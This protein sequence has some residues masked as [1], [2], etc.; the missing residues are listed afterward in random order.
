MPGNAHDHFDRYYA[1]KLWTMI[2]EYYREL[3]GEADTPGVL[4][5]FI[6]VLAQ[7]AATLR[8]SN[9]RLWDDQFIDL[10]SDWAVPYIGELVATRMLSPLLRRGRRIDVAKTVY[11]RRR[12]GTPRV[13]EELI[14]DITGWEGK[15]VEEF[16]LLGRARH[17]LDPEPSEYA[18]ALTGTMPG[19][20]ADLRNAHGAALAYSP[21][22][23]FHHTPDFR[24][25]DPNG[26]GRYG[27]YGIAKLGFHLYRLASTMVEDVTPLA[28]SPAGL[29]AGALAYTFDPSGR[30]IQ[31]FI[32]R[33]RTDDTSRY[34][35]E[36][37]TSAKEWEVP[38]PLS[39]RLLSE[40]RFVITEEVV[41]K[42]KTFLATSA[43]SQANADAILSTLDEFRSGPFTSEGEL[44]NIFSMT[45]QALLMSVGVFNT[46]LGYAIS[47][48]CSRYDLLPIGVFKGEVNPSE[49]ELNTASAS[50]VICCDDIVVG[51]VVPVR[52]E[53]IGS[54]NLK[55]WNANLPAEPQNKGWVIDPR[56]GRLLWIGD[57]NTVPLPPP[58]SA[59]I[60]SY[61]VGFSAPISA[62]GYDRQRSF[63]DAPDLT[64]IPVSGSATRPPGAIALANPT[65]TSQLE[66]RADNNV[67]PYISLAA[68][69]V[70]DSAATAPNLIINGL[71]IGQPAGIGNTYSLVLTGDF[72]TV[73]LRYVTLDP[74]G[75]D[76]NGVIINP[77]KLIVKNTV[78]QLVIERS[79][80][81]AITLDGGTIEELEIRDSIVDLHAATNEALDLPNC[82]ITLGRVTVFGSLKTEWLYATETIIVGTTTVTNTQAGCFRFSATDEF[83]RV[84]H[85][86]ESHLVG[87][88][89]SKIQTG[90]DWLQSHF[91]GDFCASFNSRVFG[92]YAYGQLT[93]VAPVFLQRGAENGSEIGAFSSLL[94]PIK[95]DGLKSKI[96]EFAPFG[97][98]P[99]FMFET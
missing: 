96:D 27:R 74:G 77:I 55:L 46:L 22:D 19:G 57:V 10:C 84:P 7:Q 95:F 43:I 83:S 85:P 5:G 6:E 25:P 9:D 88:F 66:I 32:R 49:S 12:A 51:E 52:R 2:P 60:V 69:W 29:T 87:Q 28:V 18:G 11:Y 8:R 40:A 75:K 91:V 98:L 80:L 34:D 37:W 20:W 56:R 4:R 41:S 59:P 64:V 35:W 62:G 17:G 42:Y 33:N 23:E 58:P 81:G 3:D 30:D 31:L 86:Y 36:S 47:N 45:Q 93:Q 76:W 48:D 68:D 73:T 99:V 82:K 90:S 13:L 89:T 94:N 1:E 53:E 26:A 24:R 65:N 67:R 92:H 54:G 63:N 78:K 21:F 61:H 79:I 50:I 70:L 71:W 39:C 16:K 97:L 44:W 15:L 38:A 14:A 72:E